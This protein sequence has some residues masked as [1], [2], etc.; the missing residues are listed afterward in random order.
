MLMQAMQ[1]AVPIM[2][3]LLRGLGSESACAE[4]GLI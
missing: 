2:C 1:S 4:N 3:G